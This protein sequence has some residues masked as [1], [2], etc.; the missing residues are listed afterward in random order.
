MISLGTDLTGGIS[1]GRVSPL[2]FIGLIAVLVGLI[3]LSA[4]RT[5]GYERLARH[6]FARW[7]VVPYWPFMHKSKAGGAVWLRRMGI[8]TLLLGIVMLLAALWT[9]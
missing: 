7:L 6:R 3:T 4:A 9:S 1:L 5:G 2:L 8:M